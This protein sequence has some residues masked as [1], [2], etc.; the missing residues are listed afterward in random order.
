MQM[1]KNALKARLGAGLPCFGTWLHTASPSV[2]EMVSYIGLDFVII[3]LEHGPG[4]VDTAIAMMQA[5]A[6][7][8]TTA[9]VRIPSADPA[10]L[11]RM[12]DAGAQSL[13]IPMV[14]SADEA[15]RIVDACLYPPRGQRGNAA[16]VVRGSR[17]GLVED[18]VARAHEEMLIVPQIETVAAVAEAGAIAAVPGIDMVFI[19][20]VDLSGSA[21]LPGETGA[22]EVERLIAKAFAAI[23][24]AGKPVGTVPRDGKGWRDLFAEDYALVATGSDLIY[25]R[26]AVRTQADD[27]RRYM[28]AKQG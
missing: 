12:V 28:E 18:Y 8:D 3:D 2:A 27:W 19:G 26:E 23:R 11:K 13:L 20:P 14:N 24:A 4:D 9:M 10:C 6:A 17:Y 22:P 15:R 1:T 16:V 25:I 7:S 21:G 5:M